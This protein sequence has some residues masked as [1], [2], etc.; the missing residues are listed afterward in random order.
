MVAREEDGQS[1]EELL[2]LALQVPMVAVGGREPQ[3]KAEPV[4]TPE[5]GPIGGRRVE[6]RRG[7]NRV[8]ARPAEVFGAYPV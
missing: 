8:V 3:L 1:R 4:F 7:P 2:A 6:L 5:R